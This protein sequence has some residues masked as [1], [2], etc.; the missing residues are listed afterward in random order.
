MTKFFCLV[1]WG[2]YIRF[3]LHIVKLL[4]SFQRKLT[5][6]AQC[7]EHVEDVKGADENVE[8]AARIGY[9]S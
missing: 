9:V 2:I 6:A 1:A 3:A 5:V 8:K 7:E 4:F